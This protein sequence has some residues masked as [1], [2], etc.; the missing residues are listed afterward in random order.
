MEDKMFKNATAEKIYEVIKDA[1]DDNEEDMLHRIQQIKDEACLRIE[2]KN[3]AN[4]RLINK[5]KMVIS[6]IVYNTEYNGNRTFDMKRYAIYDMRIND[7]Y[8]GEDPIGISDIRQ[9]KCGCIQIDAVIHLEPFIKWYIKSKDS[10]RLMDIEYDNYKCKQD[11]L[12][13]ISN[14]THEAVKI[15]FDNCD[16]KSS[17]DSI[18]TINMFNTIYDRPLIVRKDKYNNPIT[19]S[20]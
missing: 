9:D 8:I 7:D 5:L 1:T 11:I 17:P 12:F 2:K 10:I 4:E 19:S 15:I 16:G 6:H 20:S 13:A 18:N 14:A 3:K